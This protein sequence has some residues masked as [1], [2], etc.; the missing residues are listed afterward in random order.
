MDL[1]SRWFFA[2]KNTNP[3]NLK[4]LV[5]Y[6]C[7]FNKH[8][9]ARCPY[10]K[11]DEDGCNLVL[12]DKPMPLYDKNKHFKKKRYK[13]SWRI[14]FWQW[15]RRRWGSGSDMTNFS[16]HSSSSKPLFNAHNKVLAIYSMWWSSRMSRRRHQKFGSVKVV[17]LVSCGWRGCP[18][19]CVISIT[20]TQLWKSM[21][22]P[23]VVL[24][25]NDNP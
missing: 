10:E 17:V 24:V 1:A 19:C 23:C 4:F 15:R 22:V 14:L 20:V 6:N 16:H 25:I 5:R 7:K 9:V 2:K 13:V 18:R 21:V 8:F 3:N 12:K 11:R